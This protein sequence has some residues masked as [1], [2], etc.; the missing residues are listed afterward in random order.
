MYSQRDYLHKHM[1]RLQEQSVIFCL[2]AL[3]NLAR[4][5][6]LNIQT[7]EIVQSQTFAK[8]LYALVIEMAHANSEMVDIFFIIKFMLKMSE[9]QDI[10]SIV[11][12]ENT[13]KIMELFTNKLNEEDSKFQISKYKTNSDLYR[14]AKVFGNRIPGF[15]EFVAQRWLDIGNRINSVELYQDVLNIKQAVERDIKGPRRAELIDQMIDKM[16][17]FQ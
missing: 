1:N 5:D 11:S 7:K 9:T 8:D 6:R 14:I 2:N 4:A 15:T 12:E 16:I 10:R 13:R 3:N 17:Q